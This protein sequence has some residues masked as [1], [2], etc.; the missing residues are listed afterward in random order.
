[1]VTGDKEQLAG[2]SEAVHASS[3]ET[4]PKKCLAL[5]LIRELWLPMAFLV[6]SL[7]FNPFMTKFQID[8]D[9]GVNLMKGL[10][11]SD[12]HRMYTDIWSDQPPL[13]TYVLA[14]L[15]RV[16]GV[17]VN[18]GRL[19]V[20]LM[21]CTLLWAGCRA[22]RVIAGEV[23]AI[24]GGLLVILI[25]DF[26]KLSS[27]VMVGLPAI[28]LAILS[29][30]LL[31]T[32]Q[33]KR[34]AAWLVLSAVILALSIMT[35]A[36]T[37]FLIVVPIGALLLSERLRPENSMWRQRLTAPGIWAL[38]FGAALLGLL[39]LCV[40][41]DSVGQLV[42]GHVAGKK[43]LGRSYTLYRALESAWPLLALGVLGGVYSLLGRRWW[44]LVFSAWVLSAAFL[45]SK[46]RP[47]WYHQQLLV[48]V[49]AALLGGYAVGQGW[50]WACQSIKEG[51][52]R[53]LRAVSVLPVAAVLTWLMVCQVPV[54]MAPC[55]RSSFLAN[56]R[57]EVDGGERAAQVARYAHETKWIVTD[58]PMYAYRAGL[59]TPP[60]LAVTSAKRIRT[61]QLSHQEILRLIREYRVEQVLMVRRDWPLVQKYLK[62]DY[63]LVYA[64]GRSRLFV[65]KSLARIEK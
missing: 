22:L 35:K 61:G 57:E 43:A 16:F 6:F 20:L 13:L 41:Y 28:S 26:I 38:S 51:R 24:A 31:L 58:R 15:V 59:R 18:P 60:Y 21:S 63:D 36:F 12:G 29:M 47:V 32:W 40:G 46:H 39:V 2:A 64:K 54:A 10:L 48:S 14:G 27:A 17:T 11:V 8:N 30:A 33:E 4:P 56:F 34:K 44:C 45:L 49:P 52:S 42:F 62:K 25:P 23:H 65:L 50:Q 53:W 55:R 7:L 5:A 1:M 9:E 37:S 19:F 3:T